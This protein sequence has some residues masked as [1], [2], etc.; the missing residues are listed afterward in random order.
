MDLMVMYEHTKI[1][2]IWTELFVIW[3]DDNIAWKED[4][5]VSN[6]IKSKKWGS[7]NRECV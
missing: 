5:S 2:Y 1:L 4:G 3:M 7:G 6:K